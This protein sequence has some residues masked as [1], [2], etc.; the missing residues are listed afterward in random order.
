M[1][2]LI[3]KP[4][5]RTA[6]VL[7]LF[8]T[9]LAVARELGR[10][11]IPVYGF[12]K[13]PQPGF[14]S[15]YGTHEVCPD[16][17]HE[18]DAL[19]HLLVERARACAEPP[20]LYPTADAFVGFISEHRDALAP[21]FVH[22]LPS[23]DAVAIA[24]DKRHQ[25]RR[26]QEAAVPTAV[27]C[28]PSTMDEIEALAPT[29]SYPV[30]IKPAVGHIWREQF[31]REKALRVEGPE[32]LLNLC[33]DIFAH[34]Q[35]AMIQSII[36]GPNTNHCKV[37]AYFDLHGT[38]LACICMRKIRQYPTD[39]G[40]GTML[41]SVDDPELADLG[42]RFF[43]AMQWR[44]PGSIEFKRDDR[45]GAWKLIELNPRLWQQHGLAAACGVS[46]PLIQYRDLTGQAPVEQQYRLGVRWVNEV[47][48][49]QSSWRHFGA[50]TLTLGQWT[51]SFRGV[52]DFALFAADDPKPFI[53]ALVTLCASTL[54]PG[55]RPS[56]TRARLDG[57]SSPNAPSTGGST[58][59]TLG[60]RF[61][62][63][64]RHLKVVQKRGVQ[65][66]LR[67]LDQGSLAP[68]P[69]GMQLETD[70]VNQLFAR[71]AGELGLHCRQI[72]NFLVIEDE[73]G[74]LLRM[75][76]PYH[77][78]DSFA[79][80]VACGDK[81]L[82]R[83]FLEDAGLPIPRG[84]A[85][86]FEE[87]H[88]AVDFA[89]SMGTPCVIKPARYTSCSAGVNVG[90]RTEVEIRKG[91]RRSRLYS[92]VVLIE[93]HVFGDDYRILVYKGQCLSVVL[94]ERPCVIGNGRDSI[95]TLVRHV[96]ARRISSLPWKLGDPELMP[97]RTDTSTRRFLAA[98]GLSL[99]SV[100][101]EGRR[102]TLSGLAN[103]AIGSTYRECI[104]TTHPAIVHAA[105]SA[106]RALGV[107]LA[108]IDIIAT[109][110]SAPAHFINEVNTTPGTPLH[111]FV[112]NRE[113][114]V[115]PFGIILKDLVQ[116]RLSHLPARGALASTHAQ[117]GNSPPVTAAIPVGHAL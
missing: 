87:E 98:Q 32:D 5:R 69:N 82:S 112:T 4:P 73:H 49:L 45:D 79:A 13:I 104:R 75:A 71:S 18:Q 31:R 48:D 53:A 58:K 34:G 30:I 62:R 7:G 51:R 89:L 1:S 68:R 65:Q 9:G 66:V 61:A 35:T 39:F 36:V 86:Q 40:I 54:R 52:D 90:L 28:W 57:R 113:E 60:K 117:N 77:D 94:R 70:S 14:R 63:W 72:S 12:D 85:F 29:L 16:P 42:L 110:I 83:R 95:A 97:L 88:K 41:E 33:A 76:G 103:F 43:R 2:G 67:A 115:D 22:A 55:V 19:V 10:A 3:Q 47:R 96:N 25:H 17:V 100:P 102:V 116:S 59:G 15:R 6:F 46:F 80:G 107:V 26:A 92:D 99:K 20:I 21:H 11:G 24:M 105:E 37:C 64:H 93:E 109:D 50:G 38:A 23:R 101:A 106:A 44:G 108:G 27:T 56:R 111:Y 8:D 91:F 74:P 81:V 78:L 84:A 114:Q